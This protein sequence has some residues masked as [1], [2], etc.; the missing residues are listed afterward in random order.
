MSDD[1]GGN[2]RDEIDRARLIK[3][4]GAADV[5]N[6]QPRYPYDERP[7]MVPSSALDIEFEQEEERGAAGE[8]AV[9]WH[10][11]S[12]N[13]IGAV[14]EH[15]FAFGAADFVGSNNWVISGEYTASGLPL[16]ANDPH[17]GIQMPAIWYEIGLHLDDLNLVG[18]SFAGVPGIV[19]GHNDHIAWGVTNVGPDVQDL[20]IEKINP[21]NPDQYEFAGEWQNMEVIEEVIQV[22][23]GEE[24]RLEVRLTRHGPIITALDA[25]ASDLLA[26]RWAAHEPSRLFKS[27]YLLNRAT[28]VAE[29][30]EALRYWDGPSQNFV[31]ADVEGNIAYQAP[32]R[33]PIRAAG[34][35]LIPVPGWSGEYEWEGWIPYEELP[36]LIN[37][38]W[39][40]IVTANHAVV[41][42]AY[43]YLIEIYWA[44]GDR[45]QRI[46]DMIEAEIAGDGT[47]SIADIGRMQMDSYSYL[48]DSYIPLLEGL[49]S[50]NADVQAA[51]ER[52]RGWDKQLRRDSVPAALFEIFIM[53]MAELTLADNV[54]A[55]NVDDFRS[56]ILLHQLAD[57]PEAVW[58]DDLDT[59]RPKHGKRSCWRRWRKL[60]TGLQIIQGAR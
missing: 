55:S 4:L 10:N 14:P 59:E 32:G 28:D 49:S 27:L 38:D 47:I 43:P 35:G 45:G 26:M 39:G 48:A 22:N 16:L 36:Y 50:D 31:Y 40:Y 15:G 25:D 42:E 19:V 24:E 33:I 20:F 34:D 8:T 52:L 37:P 17:L 1:L 58:W 41:D 18:F 53:Q 11:V 60:S 21:S 54:G 23:G 2:W 9:N 7:V 12:T 3:E 29:F 44:D 57:D 46:T 5:A 56:N 13:L 30:R 6:L 51:L